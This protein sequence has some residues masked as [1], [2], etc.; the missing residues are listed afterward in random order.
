MRDRGVER[1]D[2]GTQ[3]SVGLTFHLFGR[4]RPWEVTCKKH[5]PDEK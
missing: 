5:P 3:V 4:I 1:R 2:V